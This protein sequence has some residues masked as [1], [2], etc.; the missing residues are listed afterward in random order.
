LLQVKRGGAGAAVVMLAIGLPVGHIPFFPK[1]R[2]K[3]SGNP[4]K[5]THSLT[6][7]NKI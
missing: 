6:G 5:R 4:E 7:K 1:V 3:E 2:E